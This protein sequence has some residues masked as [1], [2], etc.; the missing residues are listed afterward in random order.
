MMLR[1][2]GGIGAARTR[3]GGAPLAPVEQITCP[4]PL[5][6]PK[7][8]FSILPFIAHFAYPIYGP[9][10]G[11]APMETIPPRPDTLALSGESR[12]Y[13]GE[14]GGDQCQRLG[15]QRPSPRNVNP[16]LVPAKLAGAIGSVFAVKVVHEVP[17]KNQIF[18]LV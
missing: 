4:R 3:A 10:R 13:L 11:P 5:M 15:T 2:K 8:T 1:R 14:L 17:G 9:P 18:L 6:G 16:K 7:P 12:G